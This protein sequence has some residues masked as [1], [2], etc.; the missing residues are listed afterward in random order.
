MSSEN[1]N[2]KDTK[3]KESAKERQTESS[4]LAC[5]FPAHSTVAAHALKRSFRYVI[6]ERCLL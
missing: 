4:F 2:P 6:K 5:D 1:E 3:L